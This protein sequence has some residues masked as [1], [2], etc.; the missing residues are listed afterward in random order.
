MKPFLATILSAM[1]SSGKRLLNIN[2]RGSNDPRTPAECP[3]FGIDS[4]PFKGSRGYYA[5]TST[6]TTPD[7]IIGYEN[8]QVKAEAGET[9]VYSTDNTGAFKYNVWVRNDGTVFIGDSDVPSDYTKNLTQYQALETAFN[10]LKGKHNDLVNAFNAHMHPTAGTG[11]PSTPTAI[12]GSIPAIPS[13]A[14]IT[15]AK[16]DHIKTK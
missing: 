10:E 8:T 2:G 1:V 11:A 7:L 13:S 12:P 3:D 14:N 15:P 16:I 4:V 6:F 5:S 9:R